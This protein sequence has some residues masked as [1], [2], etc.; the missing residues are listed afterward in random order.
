MT[1][2]LK[3]WWQRFLDGQADLKP[4]SGVPQFVAML[5]ISPTGWDDD[6][7]VHLAWEPPD[8]SRTPGGWVQG[9]F[10]GVVLDMAQTFALFTRLE[11]GRGPMTLEMKISYI[12]SAFTDRYRVSARPIRWGRHVGHTDARL[13]DTDGK[14]IATSTATFVIRSMP[15]DA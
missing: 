3:P 1:T 5:G 12:D 10:I 15:V 6:G 9:G 11:A 14:L 8:W 2:P 7:T 4:E 13:E